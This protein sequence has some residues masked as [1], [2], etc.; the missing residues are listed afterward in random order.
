MNADRSSSERPGAHRPYHHGHLRR[1]LLDAALAAIE[2]GGPAALNLRALARDVGV[3]HAAPT[4]HF[5]D[6]TGLLTA[7][8]AEGYR[9]QADALRA[10]YEGTGSFVEV[11]VAYVRFAVEHR[12][13]FAVMYRP[14]LYRSDDPELVEAREA[15]AE[16]LYGPIRQG[17]VGPV[18]GDALTAG[19]AAWSLVHGLATLWLDGALPP[20]VGADPERLARS[21]AA[22][23][24][25]AD[26]EG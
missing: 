24:F 22:H 23:L 17:A 5:R 8:A 16:T 9:L 4:H 6:R 3:S 20:A 11:G 1:A 2:A 19:I 7:L 26:R 12:A 15:S 21:V 14:D 10:A 25:R 13:H 18:D